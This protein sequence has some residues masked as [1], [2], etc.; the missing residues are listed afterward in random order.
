MLVQ[1]TGPDSSRGRGRGGEEEE[2]D[3]DCNCNN[4]NTSKTSTTV[5]QK[6][7][8]KLKHILTALNIQGQTKFLVKLKPLFNRFK[9]KPLRYLSN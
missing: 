7:L 4:T 3:D 2:E 9:L 6:F 8:V 5:R 1:Y